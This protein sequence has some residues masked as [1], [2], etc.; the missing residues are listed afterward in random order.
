MSRAPRDD[1]RQ[2]TVEHAFNRI[3]LNDLI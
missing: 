3:D 2:F 1:T